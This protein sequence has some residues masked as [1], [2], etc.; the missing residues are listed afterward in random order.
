MLDAAYFHKTCSPFLFPD[1]SSETPKAPATGDPETM[2]DCGADAVR[3]GD[4][5]KRFVF[6]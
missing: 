3:Q 6:S 5:G 1:S 4:D 2:S